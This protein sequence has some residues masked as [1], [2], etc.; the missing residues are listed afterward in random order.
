MSIVTTKTG[1]KLF[2]KAKSLWLIP[3]IYDSDLNDYILGQVVYDISAIIGD[4]ITLEQQ[5]GTS[6]TK[7]NEFI[8]EP[9][10]QNITS[11]DW[12][13]T[14]QCLDL[15]N[16]VL[17]SMFGAYTNADAG[18]A[19]FRGEYE[20]MFAMIR[21]RFA[22]SNTPDVYMPKVQMNSRLLLEQMKTRG[23]QGNLGGTVLSRRCA[24]INT[25]ASGRANGS[26]LPLSDSINGTV[27]YEYA[28]PLLF[29]PQGMTPLIMH[30]RDEEEGK[31]VYDE[32]V[33]SPS[34]NQ[35]C[36]AHGRYTLDDNSLG[37]GIY[38]IE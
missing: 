17:K 7:N 38:G 30:H 18:V 6:Q 21:I 23:S 31:T 3:Y 28:T 36:C 37:V 35:D 1:R 26:L 34:T 14:A 29:V 33:K 15:Q 32:I 4:S 5:D 11:G 25:V 19:A 27:V 9:L 12:K 8:N 13:V 20:T 22:D 2:R 16:S 24:V 10:V